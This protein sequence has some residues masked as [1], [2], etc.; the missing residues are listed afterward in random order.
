MSSIC[1]ICCKDLSTITVTV[2]ADLVNNTET[3]RDYWEQTPR[4]F[5]FPDRNKTTCLECFKNLSSWKCFTK[6]ILHIKNREITGK[7]PTLRFPVPVLYDRCVIC[8][9]MTEYTIN[10]SIFKRSNY[11]TGMGQFCPSCYVATTNTGMV[12]REF[13]Q[14]YLF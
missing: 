4:N 6:K 2:Q 11:L 7:K 13:H 3:W 1:W 10:T 12:L 5:Y 9:S 14:D 8:K